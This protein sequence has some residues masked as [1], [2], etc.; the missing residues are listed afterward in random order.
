MNDKQFVYYRQEENG[1]GF[2]RG[3]YVGAEALENQLSGAPHTC[4]YLITTSLLTL[5]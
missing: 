2:S 5:S 1:S 3:A 4:W